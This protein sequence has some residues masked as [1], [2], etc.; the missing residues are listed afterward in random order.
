MMR[1]CQ[2]STATTPLLVLA[3]FEMSM[4]GY[5]WVEAAAPAES[6]RLCLGRKASSVVS[7]SRVRLVEDAFGASSMA[8]KSAHVVSL[9]YASV[10]VVLVTASVF[11]MHPFPSLVLTLRMLIL[12]LWMHTP[13]ASRAALRPH[14]LVVPQHFRCQFAFMRMELAQLVANLVEEASRP[15]HEEVASLKLMLAR[16]GVS[17][18]PPEACSSDGQEIATVQA[19][20]PLGSAG[21]NSSVVE[22]TQDLHE[23]CG[24]SSVVLELLELIGGVAMPP[25]IDEVRS[26]SHEI[27]A[28]TSSPS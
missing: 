10:V 3:L 22:I 28:V 4:T 6:H 17:L 9:P 21:L 12:V 24:D 20:F 8:T 11:A 14:S 1:R 7:L 19:L 25:S 23:V 16:V 27:S 5:R 18:E 26:D 2:R 15:L 13:L